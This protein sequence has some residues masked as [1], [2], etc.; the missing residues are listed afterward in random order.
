MNEESVPH[1][2]PARTRRVV[3]RLSGKP[4]EITRSMK[5]DQ[6]YNGVVVI[7]V[8]L[9]DEGQKQFGRLFQQTALPLPTNTTPTGVRVTG[10]ARKTRAPRLKKVE[11]V[12]QSAKPEPPPL[13]KRTGRMS[14]V[15]LTSEICGTCQGRCYE[16]VYPDGRVSRP[17]A[18]ANKCFRC[19]NRSRAKERKKRAELGLAPVTRTRKRE[20]V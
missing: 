12:V 3:L 18:E 5:R 17:P 6:H 19:Y 13:G 16:Y 7:P 15:R 20:T 1:E 14:Q 11:K 9:S 4:S 8:I 10:L 2:T